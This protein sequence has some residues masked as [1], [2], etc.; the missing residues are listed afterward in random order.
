MRRR[1]LAGD[2][3]VTM[4]DVIVA[5]TLMSV[6]MGIFTDVVVQMFR[7]ANANQV[8]ASA[9]TQLTT[10]FLRLDKEIRYAAGISQPGPVGADSYVEYRTV[11]TGTPMCTELRLN[12]AEGQLQ[13]RTWPDG[14]TPLAPTGWIPLA[15]EVS[16]S[17]PFTFWAADTTLNFQRLQLTLDAS[18]GPDTTVSRSIDVTFTA[19]NTTLGT[20]ST[21]DC[22]EGR[23]VP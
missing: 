21:T 14:V 15:S 12:V 3:G 13:R 7:S 16:S 23:A 11:N 22:Q 20:D 6:F 5:M 4:I 18:G 2:D 9:Q 19:L 17:Q 1:R 8:I 10:V